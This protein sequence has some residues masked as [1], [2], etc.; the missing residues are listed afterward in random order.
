MRTGLP[1]LTITAF[2]FSEMTL[3]RLTEIAAMHGQKAE[4]FAHNVKVTRTDVLR[5]LINR[6]WEALTTKIV[7]TKPI[8]PKR[9]K[10][11]TKRKP[12]KKG[13]V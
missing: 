8:E 12:P 5:N 7:E 3:R 6:E 10:P 13:K 2:R 11:M 9:K 4:P 1:A